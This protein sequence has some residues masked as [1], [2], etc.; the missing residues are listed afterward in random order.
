MNAEELTQ[1]IW[2]DLYAYGEYN[3]FVKNYWNL[4]CFTRTGWAFYNYYLI[5]FKAV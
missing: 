1:K 2:D 5:F 4:C 3:T